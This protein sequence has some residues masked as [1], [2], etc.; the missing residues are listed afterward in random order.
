MGHID[1]VTLLYP[2]CDMQEDVVALITNVA[3]SQAGFFT[4]QQAR[5]LSGSKLVSEQLS[6][7]TLWSP[8][9]HDIWRLRD[10][11]EYAHPQLAYVHFQSL[12]RRGWP[13]TVFSHETALR[14][15]GFTAASDRIRCKKLQ[16]SVRRKLSLSD[17]GASLEQGF[18]RA[19]SVETIGGLL[20]TNLAE[21]LSDLLRDIKDWR[22]E[23]F[24]VVEQSLEAQLLTV[25]DVDRLAA[26]CRGFLMKSRAAINSTLIEKKKPSTPSLAARLYAQRMQRQKIIQDM[27]RK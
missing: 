19:C 18:A 11:P 7:R 15:H 25:D 2:G 1:L 21:T 13:A 4:E 24:D 14:L 27:N 20:V 6:S 23:V 3:R 26:E 9:F 17:L 16:G 8:W 10:Y 12:D 22:S 5:T